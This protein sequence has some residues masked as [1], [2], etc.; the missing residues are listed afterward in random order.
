ME[1]FSKLEHKIRNIFLAGIL[2]VIPIAVTFLLLNFI[3]TQIDPIFQPIIL[4]IIDL[5]PVLKGRFTYI[6]GLGIVMTILAIFLVGL[7]VK[8]IIGQKL[9]QL[10]ERILEKIP[11]VSSIYSSSKQFIQAVS[12]TGQED[13]FRKVILVE[14][15]RKGLWVVG[16]VTCENT[17]ETQVLTDEDVVNVFIPTTPNPT[18]G[19][20]L[21]VPK[22]DIIPLS[23]TVEEG[24]KLV[25]SGGIVPPPAD[26]RTP[27]NNSA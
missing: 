5:V 2:T 6:P 10:G 14:Y 27:N 25:V 20:L 18:S 17:G 4:E 26:K 13:G 1:L 7:F 23:M 9:V 19:F 8:N 11:V 3:F 21:L 22:K 24:L 12:L 16:F 15:P